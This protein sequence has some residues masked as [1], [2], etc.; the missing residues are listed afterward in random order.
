VDKLTL[1]ALEATLALY[2]E[3]ERAVRAIP[4]LAMLTTPVEALDARA[5]RL[6]A[7]LG[8]GRTA[9]TVRTD[10]TVGGG[11]FPGAKIPSCAVAL[12]PASPEQLEAR[13]RLGTVPVIGRIADGE[14]L[15]DLRGV[16]PELDDELG[17]LVARAL[18]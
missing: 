10:A 14:L 3:P 15:L 7:S 16:Q 12:R 5:A 18:A 13:L 6:V 11:A 4:A 17:A 2:R 9:R 8:A 1:A